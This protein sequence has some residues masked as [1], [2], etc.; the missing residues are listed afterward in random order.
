[1]P[2]L[3][4][5]LC[6]LLGGCISTPV[7]T[8]FI[9]TDSQLE[10]GYAG[11]QRGVGTICEYVP[12]GEDIES[13]RHLVTIQFMEGATDSPDDVMDALQ[14]QAGQHG[15]TLTW[16]VIEADG[17]SVLY[18]WSLLDC[19]KTGAVYQDQCELARILQGNDGVHRIAYTERARSMD[20]ERR[21]HYL[22]AFRKAYV[23]KGDDPTLVVVAP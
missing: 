14:A 13:W 3:A 9:P 6:F 15:G 1:M 21:E 12:P 7:E 18:E 4:L 8:V 11:D 20:G 5:V 19:P 23:V 10:L 22:G 17:N 2:R 16:K